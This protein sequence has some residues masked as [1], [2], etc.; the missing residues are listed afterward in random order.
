MFVDLRVLG[1]GLEVEGC[2]CGFVDFFLISNFF[3][4]TSTN[5]SLISDKFKSTLDDSIESASSP[6]SE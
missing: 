2:V 3:F 6:L 4:L 5:S 1:S